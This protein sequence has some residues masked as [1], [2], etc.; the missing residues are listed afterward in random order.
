MF[1]F[2]IETFYRFTFLSFSCFGLL[3]GTLKWDDFVPQ[4][5]KYPSSKRGMK[6]QLPSLGDH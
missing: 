2:L 1:R 6:N 4:N 5:F 3:L